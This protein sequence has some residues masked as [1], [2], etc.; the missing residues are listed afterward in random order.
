[1][2]DSAGRDRYPY[3]CFHC[4]ER[5]QLFE[6][7][8]NVPQVIKEGDAFVCEPKK[9]LCERCGAWG[10]VEIHHWAPKKLFP[11]FE[12]WP[13]SKLCRPCHE[14][15]HQVVTNDLVKKSN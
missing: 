1:M 14:K 10:Y 8:K 5:T 3:Y 2:I 9:D 12:A 13:T 11:D 4:L 7:K 15:W 6:K